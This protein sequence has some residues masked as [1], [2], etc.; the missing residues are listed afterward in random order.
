MKTALMAITACLLWST[1]FAGIKIG[2]QY[3]S[4]FGFAGMRF[5]LAGLMIIP[6]CGGIIE[7][8]NSV[9]KNFKTIITV[10]FFQTFMLYGLFY[11]G[12]TKVPGALG[13]IVIG[14]SPLVSSIGAHFFMHDDKM[15]VRHLRALLLGI[16]GIA[17]ISV[18]RKPWEL[19]GLVE[20]SG[21]ALLLGGAV[22]STA[23]NILV[24]KDTLKI[25]PLIFNSSQI[26]TGGLMLL[27]MS[28]FIEGAPASPASY[29]PEFYGALLWL[30]FVSAAAFSIW[31]ILLKTPGVRVSYLNV[32]KFIIPVSGAILSWILLP[33]ESPDPGTVAG[34]IIVA[35][36]IVIYNIISLKQKNE[37]RNKQFV[38]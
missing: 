23:G 9:V 19:S 13:A 38:K 28:F 11:W 34:M 22:S 33:G 31:F 12:M 25:N 30:A 6:F 2:L 27:I 35:A 5:M 24:A 36:S 29:P 3:S 16:T 18:S 21:M 17:L 1:A 4:P 8:F 37:T 26:F 7:Y 15:T 10:A 14:S 20:L 32:W